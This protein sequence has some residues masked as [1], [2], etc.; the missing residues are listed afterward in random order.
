MKWKRLK[1]KPSE[2]ES[3]DEQR[4]DFKIRDT[5]EIKTRKNDT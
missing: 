5:K 1:G 2:H 3:K 4:T